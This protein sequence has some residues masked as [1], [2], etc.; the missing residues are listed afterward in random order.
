MD[1]FNELLAF[2]E[3]HKEVYGAISFRRLTDTRIEAELQ[4]RK[5]KSFSTQIKAATHH[6]LSVVQ[7]KGFFVLTFT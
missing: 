1:F 3:I 6:D 7:K 2:A 5:I 4:G